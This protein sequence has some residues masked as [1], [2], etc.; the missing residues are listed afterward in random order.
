MLGLAVSLL[1]PAATSAAAKDA[2]RIWSPDGTPLPVTTSVKGTA[3]PGAKPVQPRYQVPK[4]WA[5]ATADSKA[6]SGL[7]A[8]PQALAASAGA[9]GGDGTFSATSL[10]PSGGW[11]AGNASGS[12][13]YGYQIQVPPAL[14]GSAPAVSLSYDSSSVDG[15]TSSTNAQASW[16]GDGWDY[17]P[18]FIERSYWGC[19]KHGITGSGDLCWAGNN[20]TMSLG[21]HSGELVRDDTTGTWKLKNDDGTKVEFLTGA[22]N[23]ANQGEYAKV[24]DNDGNSLYFGLNHLPGG[25]KSDPA[26]NSAWSVPVYSPNA[27]DPCYDSAKG[28]ASWCN[29]AWRWNLDYAVDSRGNLTV[30]NYATEANN[31]SR[32]AGQNQGT[33]TLTAYSRGGALTSIGYGQRLADQIT[34][35]GANKPAAKVLFATAPEGRCST[36]GGFTCAGA[37]IGTANASH[38]PDV[39]YDQNCAA[40]G[41]CNN[42][43]P[44]FWSNTRLSSI[45]TQVLTSGAY[46][47]IDSYALTHSFPDPADTSKPALW[48]ASVQRTGQDGGTIALPATA[49]TPVMLP[50]RVD[51]TNLVPA[52]AAYNRPRIQMV[53]TETGGRTNVDYNL[54]ACSRLNKTMPSSADSNTTTCY[55]VKWYPPG[56]ASGADPV[57]DWFNRY[58]VKSVTENDPITNS[59][60]KMTSYQYGPAAWHRNDSSLADTKTRTWDQFRGFANVTVTTGD[61]Q[62]GA[63][64]Q[65]RTSYLQGMDADTLASGSKRT[66]AVTNSAGEQL[67]DDDWLSGQA[68]ETGTYTQAGG[69]LTAYTTTKATGPVV[70]A[71]HARGSGLPALTARYA[72][73]STTV[74]NRALKADGGWRTTG[75]TVT[76]DPANGNRPVK[77]SDTADGL[78]ELCTLTSYATSTNPQLRSLVSGRTTVSG[79][80]TTPTVANTVSGDRSFYDDKPF[81]QAGDT[82]NLTTGQVLDRYDGTTA[83]F[84]TKG[85]STYDLYGRVTSATDPNSTDGQHTG[86]AVT[87]TTYSSAG[88]GELPNQVTVTSPAPG[89]STDWTAT[90]TLA[91]ARALP[92]TTTDLNGKVTTQTYDALGRLTAVWLP[93]QPTSALANKK[94]DYAVNG[95]NGPTTITTSALPDTDRYRQINVQIFDGLARLRQT[96]S[97]PG[98]SAYQ[99]RLI[100]DVYYDSHGRPAKE[101]PSWYNDD[102]SPNGTLFGTSDAQ[103]PAQNQTVYDGQDRPTT[104]VFKS[105]G[106]EQWRSSTSYPG[107]DRTDNNPVQG[108]TPSST[109]TDARGRTIQLWQYRTATA[110]GVISDADVTATTYTPGGQA[111]SRTDATGKNSWTYNY[112]LRGRLIASTDPDAGAGTR[113][114]DGAGRLTGTTDNRKVTL[115]R[116]YDLIGR[117]TGLFEGQSTTDPAKQL[118]A[119]S[120]DSVAA[121][122][123]K[124]A[125]A[126]RF[127]GGATGDAYTSKVYGYDEGYRSTGTTLSMPGKV[128]GQTGTFSYTT[129]ASYNQATGTLKATNTP[130]LADRQAETVNY[131]YDVNGPMLSFGSATTTYDL[132]TNYDAYGRPVRT[133]VN[134]WGTQIVST[135]NYDEATGRTVSQY[136]DKQTASTGATQQTN[137]TYDQAGRVTSVKDIANNTPAQADL[138]CFSYDYLGRLSEAWTDKGGVTV[139]PQPSV[140]GQGSCTNA[141]PAQSNVAGPAPYWQSYRYDVTGNRTS[142]VKHETSG[143]TTVSQAFPTPGK[144]NTGDGTGGAHALQSSAGSSY[145]YDAAGNTTRISTSAGSSDLAWNTEGRLS[146][147]TDPSGSTGY[148]YGPNGSLLVRTT[149]GKTTVF[150]GSDELT[151]DTSTGTAKLA[152]VR[153]Y[154]L[155]NGLTAVRSGAS[156]TFQIAD[157]HGSNTLAL[158]ATTLAESRR[159]MDPFGN[160]RGAQ[161]TSWAGDK[162]FVGG[163]KDDTTGLTALGAREYQPGSGRF[164]SPDPVL[165]DGDP[166]Q[167]NAYSYSN[168]APTYLSDPTGLR[169]EGACSG[170]CND[171]R[172]ETWSGGPGNW[173]YTQVFPPD[174][175]NNVKVDHIE[176]SKKPTNYTV[177]IKVK[178]APPKPAA[179]KQ[180]YSIAS[181]PRRCGYVMGTNVCGADNMR[182]PT[183][184]GKDLLWGMPRLIPSTLDFVTKLGPGCWFQEEACA[185]HLAEKWDEYAKSHGADTD[186]DLYGDGE[187]LA[188]IA[189][190][191]IG[192]EGVVVKA[193]RELE[194]A[195]VAGSAAKTA[196]AAE[197]AN[198]GAA[199]RPSFRD[200][201]SHIF[202][203]D[204]GHYADD[205]PANRAA[206]ESA[207]KPENLKL[208]INLGENG[209]NGSLQKYFMD[210]PDGSQVWA[211]VRNGNTIT[212]GGLNPAGKAK[213]F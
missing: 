143:D 67:T 154:T 3:A 48:L 133:T 204:R 12:F 187:T 148:L 79:A 8:A 160:P 123:G 112:D 201:L 203:N 64:G 185:G 124:P 72:A 59:P 105:L 21:G 197:G 106:Q 137:Y 191:A 84:A 182:K 80:C 128:I 156:M 194:A 177:T 134:P 206:I 171:G 70:T 174:S 54:P 129:R 100:S 102:T 155:P 27:G 82:G 33:G 95:T 61:G 13:T 147:L 73:T 93:G 71:T 85:T 31:Y 76:T 186:S 180:G 63:K 149:S 141:T 96:Q 60:Q 2:D 55:N 104:S 116:S 16:I 56:S 108:G 77:T 41:T 47:T 14:G 39:P 200:D 113:N 199:G 51:G 4:D 68:Y 83:V 89:S 169:P 139:K 165:D 46:R 157:P 103:V 15:R 88:A 144:G 24:T 114:Y 208:S 98:V 183:G 78:P 101:N 107:V 121:G 181:D 38:W 10:S 130:A 92:L 69:S 20:A 90:T 162:G 209:A 57:D 97:T 7:Q 131:T 135:V 125:T 53:T 161:P 211:E 184:S 188:S 164:I 140:P 151:Y 190:L 43:G 159:P 179:P 146:A 142:L 9:A 168:N 74:T 29:Q 158:D 28:K 166:Q 23:G 111:A 19:D 110:T 119:W 91:P 99:G 118:M 1:S 18:G 36:A 202:R 210:L 65:T 22:A 6:K 195:S 152:D 132:S 172:I 196:E 32:G 205:T 138:Q 75:S 50:N 5:P 40:T 192:A 25:D 35:K 115:T 30:Y 170:P 45:S 175:D 120:Y 37:T 145:T 173:T 94:Y 126:T 87:R 150:L 81:G 26:T 127:V 153:Y 189:T 176:F 117:Q 62:D 11:T 44:S 178:P 207:V 66:A 109:L 163:V 49:F 86:G 34:A 52:P 198:A 122:K 58:T 213:K 42:A 212:N 136:I 167:W 193:A 17:S